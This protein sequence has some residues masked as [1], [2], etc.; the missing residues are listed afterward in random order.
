MGELTDIRY[1]QLA[2]LLALPRDTERSALAEAARVRPEA[3]ADAFFAEA[4]DSDD[5]IGGPSANQFLEDRL[6]FFAGIID[7]VTAATIRLAFQQ[8]LAKWE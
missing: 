3:L 8:R 4:A 1:L 2:R 6:A 7:R 5:V